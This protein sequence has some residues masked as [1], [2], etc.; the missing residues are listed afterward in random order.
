MQRRHDTGL[1]K[2]VGTQYSNL[3]KKQENKYNYKDKPHSTG[4]IISPIAAV[5]PPR[6]CT[7]KRQDENYN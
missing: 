5:R 4:R 7:E 2:L 1:Q 3:T 6:Q